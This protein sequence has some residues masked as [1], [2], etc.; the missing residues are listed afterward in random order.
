MAS[1]PPDTGDLRLFR[2]GFGPLLAPAVNEF[3][4]TLSDNQ[5]TDC[6]NHDHHI[7]DVTWDAAEGVSG[8]ITVRGDGFYRFYPVDA[9]AKDQAICAPEGADVTLLLGDGGGATRRT[10][11]TALS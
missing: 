10:A 9:D 2:A 11:K 7:F 3:E 4:V 6:P 5:T 8:A 1:L